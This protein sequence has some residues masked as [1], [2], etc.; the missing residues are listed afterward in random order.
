MIMIAVESDG[1][2][3]RLNLVIATGEAGNDLRRFCV[4]E[5]PADVQRVIVVQDSHFRLLGAGFSFEGIALSEIRNG[6]YRLPFDFI[7]DAVDAYRP[8]CS[9]CSGFFVAAPG[10]ERSEERRVGKEG[11]SR[12]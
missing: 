1:D 2:P 7:Q 12:W 11:R 3:I 9:D 4:V 8:R 10:P 5:L 6:T